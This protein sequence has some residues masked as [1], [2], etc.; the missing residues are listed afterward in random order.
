MLRNLSVSDIESSGL[1][2]FSAFIWSNLCTRHIPDKLTPRGHHDWPDKR[3]FRPCDR[4]GAMRH[5]TRCDGQR[6]LPHVRQEHRAAPEE[7]RESCR[8]A[9]WKHG[10][11]SKTAVET[12]RQMRELIEVVL[13]GWKLRPISTTATTRQMNYFRI[14]ELPRIAP[15]VASPHSRSSGRLDVQSLQPGGWQPASWVNDASQEGSAANG[16][17]HTP[18]L[19]Q[20][21][22]R[23]GCCRRRGDESL[24]SITTLSFTGYWRAPSR[25]RSMRRSLSK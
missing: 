17:N 7:G 16:T 3:P 11:Y 20:E 25:T 9:R 4:S 24:P 13:G 21:Q 8:F 5:G 2:G 15:P 18:L 10:F 22:C 6:S 14:A 12:R 23:D 19:G 1:A